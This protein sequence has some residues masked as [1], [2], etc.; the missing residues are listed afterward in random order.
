MPLRNLVPLPIRK[1]ELVYLDVG[2]MLIASVRGHK[3][4]LTFIEAKT[5]YKWTYP[6]KQKGDVKKILPLW[7]ERA[8]NES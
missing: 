4:Y 2:I 1:L 5:R 7:K 3:Y 8:K 6:M